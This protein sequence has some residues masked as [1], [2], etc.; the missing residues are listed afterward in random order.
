MSTIALKNT[1]YRCILT[2]TTATLISAC[3][4]S[5]DG[6]SNPDTTSARG[7][8]QG[9]SNTVTFALNDWLNWSGQTL[10]STFDTTTKTARVAKRGDRREFAISSMAFQG[11]GLYSIEVDSLIGA[12]NITL[13]AINKNQKIIEFVDPAEKWANVFPGQAAIVELPEDV[14]RLVVQ[15]L[16]DEDLDRVKVGAV[17]VTPL[18][19]QSRRDTF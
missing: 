12:D 15:V 13:I 1:V 16:I 18:P 17:N 10:P 19:G 7:S 4:G 5:A 8:G 6:S 14:Y 3:G 2:I 9:N 11:Q